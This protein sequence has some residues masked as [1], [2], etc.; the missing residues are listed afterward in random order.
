M[1]GVMD[2]FTICSAVTTR[3]SHVIGRTGSPAGRDCVFSISCEPS[4]ID[5]VFTSTDAEPGV[6]TNEIFC[7]KELEQ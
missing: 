7:S 6:R 5:N 2:R 1:L 3:A 4:Q